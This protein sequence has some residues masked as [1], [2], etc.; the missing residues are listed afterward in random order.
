MVDENAVLAG[1]R[2]VEVKDLHA[3]LEQ[4]VSDA[5]EFIAGN[6]TDY[7]VRHCLWAGQS[8]DGR[9]RKDSLGKDP[10]PWE[11]AS[12]TQIHLADEVV[13]DAVRL[14]LAAT[15]RAVWQAGPVEG[16]DAEL[17]AAVTTYLKWQ[18]KNVLQDVHRRELPL[19][20]NYLDGY[21]VALLAVTWDE[22]ER[23]RKRTVTLEEIIAG[24]VEQTRTLAEARAQGQINEDLE[25]DNKKAILRVQALSDPDQDAETAVWLQSLF[26][27]MKPRQAKRAVVTLRED[28]E[29]VVPV[30]TKVRAQPL[31]TAC[32]VFRDVFFPANTTE[33]QRAP[34][35]AWRELLTP[36]ELQARVVTEDY[37]EEAVD[38]CLEQ[39]G[40]TVLSAVVL[41]TADKVLIDDMTGRIEV[42]TFYRRVVDE[43]GFT[44]IVATVTCPGVDEELAEYEVE[45]RDYPFVDFWR[46]RTERVLLQNRSIPGLVEAQQTDIKTQRDYRS[47]RLSITILPP[48]EV[49]MARAN[50]RLEFGPNTRVPMRRPGEISFMKMPT[51]DPDSVALERQIRAD[52]DNYFARA[53][54]GVSPVRQQMYAQCDVDTWL[55]GL[56]IAWRMSLR[57]SLRNN[58]GEFE[59]VTGQPAPEE[60]DFDVMLD[61]NASDLNMDFVLKKLDVIQKG[62]LTMDTMGVVDRA[63]LVEWAMRS[64]DPT[65]AARVVKSADAASN[66]EIEDEKMQLT[67]LIA[68]VEPEMKEGQNAA[69]R[70]QVLQNTIQRNPQLMQRYQG[71]EQFRAMVEARVKHFNF[72]L[73]QRE[74]AQIGRLGAMPALG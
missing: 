39:E 72:Q 15:K 9:K 2:E 35:I 41:E 28:G 29:C 74:N 24:V 14:K 49:P 16:T 36:V 40:S 20:A 17:S 54:E 27:R 51:Y 21:G 60:T 42:F 33:I 4:A 26:P 45:D 70:L 43:D 44:T 50:D 47:D 32:R 5:G 22:E 30:F 68:G 56:A 66:A 62:V 19:L 63:G 46:D 48:V 55:G 71:D 37:D 23:V 8:D 57:L 69:L 12:D 59:R 64:I 34:W 18:Q 11:G 38:K 13:N 61:F 1:E 58:P 53:T 7:E 3:E 52:V 67:Q 25:A 65:L 73:Q 6:A 31:W 10:F